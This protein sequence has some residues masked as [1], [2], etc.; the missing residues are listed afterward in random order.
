MSMENGNKMT[1]ITEEAC[2]FHRG[3]MRLANPRRSQNTVYVTGDKKS[4]DQG[5][6]SG[7][8]SVYRTLKKIH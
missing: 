8:F 2:T 7:Y 5:Q 6:L 4:Q 1:R 3:E